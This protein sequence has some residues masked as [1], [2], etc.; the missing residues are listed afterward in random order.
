MNLQTSE[1]EF[2]VALWGL[3]LPPPCPALGCRCFGSFFQADSHHGWCCKL[4]DNPQQQHD[5][6]PC[7]HLQI[8][9]LELSFLLCKNKQVNPLYMHL[10]I[11]IYI[12]T[13]VFCPPEITLNTISILQCMFLLLEFK[14]HEIGVF[15]LKGTQ[16][17][18]K[19]AVLYLC[20]TPFLV[21]CWFLCLCQLESL[22]AELSSR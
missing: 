19:L 5:E 10:D 12:C 15:L 1:L 17:I 3:C 11:H 8:C 21:L 7:L 9:D 14:D 4:S 2:K 6:T 13:L 16:K 20:T 18:K 22:S